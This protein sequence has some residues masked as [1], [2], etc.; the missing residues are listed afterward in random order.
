MTRLSPQELLRRNGIP[1]VV[2]A[3]NGKY[4]TNCPKCS[5]KYLSVK[6][7]YVDSICWFCRDCGFSGPQPGAQTDGRDNGGLGAPVKIFDYE[8]EHGQRLFQVLKFE[9]PGRPKTFASAKAPTS[10]NGRS[11]ACASFRSCCP[12]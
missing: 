7:N 2:N 11:R 8:D 12:S 3:R 1:Y 5:S 9:P 6:T 4:A 10:R